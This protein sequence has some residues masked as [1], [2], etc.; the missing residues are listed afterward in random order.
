MIR[1]LEERDV[2]AVMRIWLEGNVQAHDFVAPE[3]WRSHWEA[4]REALPRATVYV[5]EEG[6][7]VRGFIGLQGEYIAG[8]FVDGEARSRGI[9]RALLERAKRECCRLTLHVYR[10]NGRALRFYRAAGF[11]VT[12]ERL[13]GETGAVECAMEWRGRHEISGL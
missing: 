3:Y 6:A 1:E 2:D 4:V 8:L 13:D 5:Y 10:R 12:E 9:G 11:E 7:R